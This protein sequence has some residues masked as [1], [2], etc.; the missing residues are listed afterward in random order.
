MQLVIIWL[1]DTFKPDTIEGKI[2]R[3]IL[4]PHHV[5]HD[6]HMLWSPKDTTQETYLTNKEKNKHTHI[7]HIH[8]YVC[9]ETE[10]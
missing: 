8:I 6:H 5:A 7:I 9:E 4:H 10:K 2:T 1:Y 3:L